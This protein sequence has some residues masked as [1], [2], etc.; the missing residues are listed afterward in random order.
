M[1]VW[2]LS[3]IL[4]K[5]KKHNNVAKSVFNNNNKKEQVHPIICHGSDH[6]YFAEPRH[7]E[8]V[9]MECIMD[10]RGYT[11]RDDDGLI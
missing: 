6:L 4:Q 8:R 5:K 11:K 7:D 9:N 3:L 10:D 2:Q 1:I